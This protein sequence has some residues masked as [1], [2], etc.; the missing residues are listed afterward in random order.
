MVELG[1]DVPFYQSVDEAVGKVVEHIFGS[2]RHRGAPC[3]LR[4]TAR[5]R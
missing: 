2:L 1:I 5:R 3:R 4:E